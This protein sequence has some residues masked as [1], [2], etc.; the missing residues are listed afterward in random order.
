MDVQIQL[1]LIYLALVAVFACLIQIVKLLRAMLEGGVET[2]R[3]T[4]I[5][6]EVVRKIAGLVIEELNKRK[7]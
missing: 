3:T 6:D 1:T 4:V 7:Q 2:T 5:P